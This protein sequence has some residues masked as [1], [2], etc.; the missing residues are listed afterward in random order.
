MDIEK[1]KNEETLT[2]MVNSLILNKYKLI[3]L[4]I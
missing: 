4:L 1:K 2:D 3:Y